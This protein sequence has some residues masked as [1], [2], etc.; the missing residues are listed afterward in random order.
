MLTC[1]RI[2]M[3]PPEYTSAGELRAR[4]GFLCFHGSVFQ[5]EARSTPSTLSTAHAGM[6][7]ESGQRCV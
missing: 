2:R 5:S 7:N 1:A 6:I 4:T 3:K